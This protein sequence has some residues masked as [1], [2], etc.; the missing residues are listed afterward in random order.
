MSDDGAR[1]RVSFLGL[2]IMGS[3]MAAN[4]AAAG[5]PLTVWTHT[6]GKAETW[7]EAHGAQVAATPA[8]AAAAAD[9][10]VSMVVDGGQVESVMLGAD[11]VAEAARP[12]L[13]AIDCSTIGPTEARRIGAAL[14]QRGVELL[15]APVTGSSPRAEDGTLTIMAGGSVSSFERARPLLE[16]M[17][18]LVVRVGELGQGQMLKLLNNA[19]AAANAT[20]LAEA[21]LLAGATGIDADVFAQVLGAGSG[22]S[23]QL[24]TKLTAMRE[25]DFRALFKTEHM[26]KDVRLCLAEARAAGVAFPAAEHARELLEAAVERGRADEDYAS[27]VESAG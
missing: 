6:P 24:D 11:G 5:F 8:L 1:E 7:A 17:G 13:L 3:R 10:V 2:G 9:I 22:G 18:R 4:V 19:V 12:D 20:A 14:A 26:L 16:A 15:D 23:T 21:L 27:I 25:R